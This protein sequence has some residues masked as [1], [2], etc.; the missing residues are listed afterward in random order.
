MIFSQ[1]TF[2]LELENVETLC[3]HHLFKRPGKTATVWKQKRVYFYLKK[4][5]LF[6]FPFLNL[7]K[8]LEKYLLPFSTKK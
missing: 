6:H 1:G 5:F 4:L 8:M 2:T 3:R 7:T